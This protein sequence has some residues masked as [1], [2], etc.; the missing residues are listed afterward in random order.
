[1]SEVDP[2]LPFV[3]GIARSG[4]YL[5]ARSRRFMRSLLQQLSTIKAPQHQVRPFGGKC[6]RRGHPQVPG[7]FGDQ[8]GLSFQ[9]SLQSV[10]PPQKL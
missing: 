4:D 1:M 7:N 9:S 2:D 3:A 6:Q 8:N 5:R 10:T